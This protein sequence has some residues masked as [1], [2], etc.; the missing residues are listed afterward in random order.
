MPIMETSSSEMSGSSSPGVGG[1]GGKQCYGC[2]SHIHDRFYL[3]AAERQWHTACLRCS[4]CK[5]HLDNELSCFARSGAIYCKED[6]YRYAHFADYQYPVEVST[7]SHLKDSFEETSV[8]R[9]GAVGRISQS[10]M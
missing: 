4:H 2:G 10:H 8:A 7:S 5:V 6:Y 9:S 3:L 1:T